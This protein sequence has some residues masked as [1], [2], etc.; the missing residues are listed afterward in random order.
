MVD[1]VVINWKR[2]QNVL[3]IIG[4]LRAQSVNC[5]ITICD[6]AQRGSEWELPPAARDQVDTVYHFSRDYGSLTRFIPSSGYM[7]EYLLYLDDD[8]LPGRRAI[9]YLLNCAQRLP[10][11]GVLGEKGRTL[12]RDGKY[13]AIDAPRRSEAFTEVDFIVRAGL[14]RTENLY[15]I[16]LFRRRMRLMPGQNPDLTRHDDLLLCTALK[17]VKNLRC[18]LTPT[19]NGM[20]DS[21][22]FRQEL[23]SPH[24]I[25]SRPDHF[26]VRTQFLTKAREEGWR[27]LAEDE[28]ARK[29]GS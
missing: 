13:R 1:A 19:R 3:R 6:A 18:Y 16:D 21:R 8:L 4:A 23:P 10:E 15:C 29:L 24:A 7:Q 22:L 12:K 20:D 28:T 25:S 9:E 11:F 2:P 26:Q 5:V 17:T 27:S 14:V